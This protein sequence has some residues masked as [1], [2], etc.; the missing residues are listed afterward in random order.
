MT[1]VFVAAG[2]SIAAQP[3]MANSSAAAADISSTLRTSQAAN[4]SV[5]GGEDEQFSQLFSSWQNYEETG[6][7][8]AKPRQPSAASPPS[9]S[10]RATPSL[11]SA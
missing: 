4:Q 11:K 7:A 1:G 2:L 9:P 3:A 10:P 8:A 5:T 6:L